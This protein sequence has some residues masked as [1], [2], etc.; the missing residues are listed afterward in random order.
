MQPLAA[1]TAESLH[2]RETGYCRPFALCDALEKSFQNQDAAA[3]SVSCKQTA[4]GPLLPLTP[5][6]GSALKA[7]G[8]A[9]PVET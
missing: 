5:V 6:W 8:T 7:E 4:H 3:T 2:L 9:C 1:D